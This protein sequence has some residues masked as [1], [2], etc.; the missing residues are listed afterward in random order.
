MKM[1]SAVEAL[2]SGADVFRDRYLL[3]FGGRLFEDF[4]N[5]GTGPE[6]LSSV[7]EYRV[8]ARSTA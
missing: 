3:Y 7:Q 2:L 5:G 4:I 8:D 1:P 6:I